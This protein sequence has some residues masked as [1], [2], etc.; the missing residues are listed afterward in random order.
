MSLPDQE[1]RRARWRRV[2]A[3]QNLDSVAR[4]DFAQGGLANRL[5]RAT[6]RALLLPEDPEVRAIDFDDEFWG[7]FEAH[8]SIEIG[9]DS[10]SLGP[11]TGATA[12][13]AVAF[14]AWSRN[15]RWRRYAAVH[16]SGV[17]ELSLGESAR[18]EHRRPEKEVAAF[19]NLTTMVAGGW[20]L[21]ELGALVYERFAIE[22]PSM[23]VE[24]CS[25]TSGT[26][27]ANFGEGWREPT[28][29]GS[30]DTSCFDAALLWTIELADLGDADTRR[31]EAFRMGD[32]LEN[33]WG[34]KHRRYLAR[35]GEFQGE[36]DVRRIHAR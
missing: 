33:A 19:Y 5:D 27:L 34:S 20:A 7:W 13:A 12:H 16:S 17:V 3:D 36:L 35:L 30:H 8:T 10:Y 6:F 21:L 23:L 24:A 14:E 26:H 25:D 29:R 1:L 31:A 11:Q 9:R 2:L 28:D 18:W 22:G 32:R 15:E 4:S